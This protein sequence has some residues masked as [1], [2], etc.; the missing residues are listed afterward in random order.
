MSPRAM[1]IITRTRM[2][3]DP[4]TRASLERR[5]QEGKTKREIRRW[6]KRATAKQRCGKIKI[7]MP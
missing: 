4:A 7:T 5:I 3:S 2:R 6:L 1:N